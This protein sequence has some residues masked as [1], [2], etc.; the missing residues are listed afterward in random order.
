MKKIFLY[1][2]LFFLSSTAMANKAIIINSSALAPHVTQQ[3]DSRSDVTIDMQYPLFSGN[4]LSVA[5]QHFNKIIDTFIKSELRQFKELVADA[6]NVEKGTN[7]ITVRYKILMS[8]AGESPL[9]STLFTTNSF[10]KGGAYPN[11]HHYTVN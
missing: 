5:T 9:L 3:H 6:S 8:K 10:V 2:S 11:V 7:D 1:L 4:K